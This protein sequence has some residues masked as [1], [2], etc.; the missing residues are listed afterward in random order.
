MSRWW[1][2]LVLLLAG[3]AATAPPSPAGPRIAVRH[4][5]VGTSYTLAAAA[6]EHD[7]VV[8]LWTALATGV[9]GDPQRVVHL[10]STDLETWEGD[11]TASA[12]DGTAL[13]FDANGPVPSSVLVEA[14]GSWRMFGGGR[15][16]DRDTSILWTATSPGPDG[17]WTFHPAPI[18]EPEGVGWD[19]LRLDH[20]SVLHVDGGYLMAYGGASAMAPN[21]NRIGFASSV[22]GISWIRV[23]T[24]LDGADDD[25][26]LGPAA[27]GIDA[28]TMVEP[29]LRPTDGGAMRLDFGLMEVGGDEMVIASATGSDGSS[30]RCAAD[31]PIFEAASVDAARNLHS[32]LSLRASGRHVFLVELLAP[33]SGSSDLWL[34]ER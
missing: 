32:F 34:V 29:E 18:L 2:P 21:R 4:D 10:T 30:W 31:G 33:D 9:A 11:A 6:I 19:G 20:P 23:P 7:G 14:D 25:L 26:A 13:G 12:L 3:C 1:L 22:D 17:P 16:A 28:R 8:H 5:S 27:C 15:L 24:S